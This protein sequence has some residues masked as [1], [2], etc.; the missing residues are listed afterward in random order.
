MIINQT[1]DC[2]L[3]KCVCGAV[4]DSAIGSNCAIING[5]SYPECPSCSRTE[6]LAHSD[7]TVNLVKIRCSICDKN[8]AKIWAA[9]AEVEYAVCLDCQNRLENIPDEI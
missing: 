5:A 8:K 6:G 7:N 9:N 1:E 4:Y 2:Y 3:V